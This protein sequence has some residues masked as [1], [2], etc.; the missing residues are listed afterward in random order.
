MAYIDNFNPDVPGMT[1]GR[2]FA[3]KQIH[4]HPSRHTIP[5][6][7][8]PNTGDLDKGT[9]LGVSTADGL[10]RPVIRTTVKA[11]QPGNPQVITVSPG[12]GTQ[13]TVGQIVAAMHADGSGVQQLGAIQAING[14][15]VTVQT[16]LQSAL[17]DG[18]YLFVADGSQKAL[19]VLAYPVMDSTQPKIAQADLGGIYWKDQLVGLDPIAIRDLGAR[20]IPDNIL[21]IPV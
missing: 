18:D 1:E 12:T 13:F 9:I 7:I 11:T 19:V 6:T 21:V 4:V 14:D 15:A 3:D 10:Y 16:S 17:N 5:I 20:E 8:A 2:T